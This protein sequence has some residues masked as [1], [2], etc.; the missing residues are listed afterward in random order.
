M[1]SS[2]SSV[3]EQYLCTDVLIPPL[4]EV[5]TARSQALVKERGGGGAADAKNYQGL[6]FGPQ[7]FSGPLF[8]QGK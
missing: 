2:G 8:P 6:P 7:S 4:P 1:V 5:L 3:S